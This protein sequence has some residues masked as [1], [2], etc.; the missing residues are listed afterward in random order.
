MID[1]IEF[2]KKESEIQ[3]KKT[4]PKKRR[5]ML[6]AKVTQIKLARKMGLPIEQTVFRPRYSP[7]MPPMMQVKMVANT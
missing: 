7:R 2:R 5:C 6:G 1:C 4:W 3:L